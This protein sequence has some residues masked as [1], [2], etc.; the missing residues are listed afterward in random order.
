MKITHYEILVWVPGLILL[1]FWLYFM[2]ER[3][4]FG[5]AS[6]TF[7]NWIPALQGVFLLSP[8]WIIYLFVRRKAAFGLI[9]LMS[10]CGSLLTL[11][12]LLPFD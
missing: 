11:V 5:Y 4:I 6:Y 10:W 1:T 2:G 8:I 7:M 9:S 3:L 12:A